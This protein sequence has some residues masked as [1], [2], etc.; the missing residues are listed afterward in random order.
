MSQVVDPNASLARYVALV[1]AHNPN[2]FRL[3]SV[4]TERGF[5]EVTEEALEL[6][7]RRIE[8]GSTHYRD[9]D[10]RGLSRLLADFLSAA[11]YHAAAERDNNGHVDVVVEHAFGG[12][13]KYLGECKIH[14]GFQYHVDGCEQLLAYCAGRELRAFCLDFFKQPAMLERLSELRKRM[15]REKPLQ[16]VGPS[17]DHAMQGAFTTSHPHQNGAP[18][19]I[20]HA[21]CS[22][23]QE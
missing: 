13:W 19:G 22:V 8:S 4:T 9:L 16:Q 21:G 12:R 23:P 18:I 17:G 2:L 15:D 1:E 7:I 10:E 6:A 5:V 3:L 11:G 14:R 20:L